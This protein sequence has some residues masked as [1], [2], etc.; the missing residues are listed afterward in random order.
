MALWCI[1]RDKEIQNKY[2]RLFTL[3]QIGAC[4]NTTRTFIN[5]SEK[6]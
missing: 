3:I 2:V 6:K 5:T 1:E 4:F